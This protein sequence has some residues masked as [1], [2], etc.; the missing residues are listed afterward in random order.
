MAVFNAELAAKALERR[1]Q[2][3]ETQ[4]DAVNKLGRAAG[5]SVAA[6][7]ELKKLAADQKQR[8]ETLEK[9]V[10]ALMET[11]GDSKQAALGKF[12]ETLRELEAK[13]QQDRN[14]V[15]NRLNKVDAERLKLG[16]GDVV[17]KEDVNKLIDEQIV[18]TNKAF[19]GVAEA[20]SRRREVE[21][22]RK[23]QAD[24]AA[25]QKQLEAKFDQSIKAAQRMQQ[26]ASERATKAML[27]VQL[28]ILNARLNAIEGRMNK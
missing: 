24:I 19:G 20:E 16:I 9:L 3:L 27:D 14:E 4:L 10:K 5:D 2:G 1:V 13:Q 22:E 7:L 25:Q 26:E 18:K 21:A 17:R 28:S 12:E 8:I 6:V 11:R 23:V 15:F